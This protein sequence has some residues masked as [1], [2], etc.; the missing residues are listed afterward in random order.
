VKEISSSGF[1]SMRQKPTI[2]CKNNYNNEDR[3]ILF[4]NLASGWQSRNKLRFYKHSEDQNRPEG[5]TTVS[6]RGVNMPTKRRVAFVR[7]RVESPSQYSLLGSSRQQT[8]C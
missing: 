5:E 6:I 8:R 7:E 3:N 2:G 4:G 1:T